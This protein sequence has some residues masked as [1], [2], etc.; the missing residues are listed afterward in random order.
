MNDRE[1]DFMDILSIVSFL[2][3]IANYEENLTQ[4]DK[5]DL[6]KDVDS[7]TAV[8]LT[9]IHAHLEKQDKMLQQLLDERM[10]SNDSD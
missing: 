1:L 9:E 3:G 8:I 10:K 7:K 6:M 4:S 2:V 5:Q